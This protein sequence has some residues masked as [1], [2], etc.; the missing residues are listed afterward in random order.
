MKMWL[1]RSNLK[2]LESYHSANNIE[3]FK[4]VCHDFYLLQ[5]IWYLENNYL[6]EAIVWRLAPPNKDP[7]KL[8]KHWKINGKWFSQV[9]VTNFEEA[10]TQGDLHADISFFR[11]GFPEYDKLTRHNNKNKLGKKLYLGAGKRTKPIYKGKY[12]KI[13][14]EEESSWNSFEVPFYKTANPS[15]FYPQELT[16]EPLYDICYIANFSQWRYKGQEQFIKDIANSKYLQSLRIVHVG[17][18]SEVGESLCKKHKVSN[19][20]FSGWVDRWEINKILNKSKFGLVYS[21][22]NDGCPRVITEVLC[23]GTPLLISENTRML[24]YYQAMGIITFKDNEFSEYV[25]VAM[26]ASNVIKESSKMHA[27]KIS[28]EQICKLNWAMWEL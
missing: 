22:K 10:L 26:D 24:E 5:L 13:L 3:D 23:S 27:D 19:I 1:F 14:F 7:L 28:M 25:D 11:G 20:K 12:D 15:I 21:N 18:K 4:K 6:D 17:N 9:W 16:E 2:I 8:N